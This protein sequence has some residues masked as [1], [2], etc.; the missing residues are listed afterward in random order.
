MA[1]APA[2]ACAAMV[3]GDERHENQVRLDD[4]SPSLGL[5]DPKR[6]GL[7]GIAGAELER[8]GGVVER[9]IGHDSAH[10]AR[11]FGR[12]MRA[13]LRAKRSIAADHCRIGAKRSEMMGEA[14]FEK[15]ALSV[16]QRP[17]ISLAGFERR[18]PQR[19]LR[20]RLHFRPPLY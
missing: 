1:L 12:G 14:L 4:R 16:A 9:R 7:Q 15:E 19:L 2:E 17:D 18:T 11:F 20:Q 3:D 6:A 5:H 10:R 8:L 13:D